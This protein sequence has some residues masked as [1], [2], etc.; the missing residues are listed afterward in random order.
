[1]YILI[2]IFLDSR[3]EY[4]RFCTYLDSVSS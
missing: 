1:L 3:W 2:F 4:K